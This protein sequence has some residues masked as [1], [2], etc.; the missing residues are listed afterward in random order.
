MATG[1]SKSHRCLVAHD[2]RCYHCNGFTLGG[3]DLA[4]HNAASG[5]ILGQT[6]FTQS[7]ARAGTKKAD[8]VG[9]LHEGASENIES[10]MGLNESIMGSQCFKLHQDGKE[11]QIICQLEKEIPCLGQ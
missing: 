2:L 3:V 5:F 8:V 9:N 7:T 10:P 1:A 11:N 4:R 6:Q